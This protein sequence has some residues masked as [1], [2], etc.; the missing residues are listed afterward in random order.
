MP[1]LL[2]VN[3]YHYRRG[4]ADVVYFEHDLAFREAGWETAM[5]AMHHPSNVPSPWSDYF[6][7]ELQY[8]HSYGLVNKVGMAAKV[9]F[10]V[11]ARRK[12]ARLLDAFKPNIAHSHNL[13]H[14]I[15]PSILPLLKQRGI[16]SVMT[17]HDLKLACPSHTMLAAD[18]ICERCKGGNFLNVVRH[19][20]IKGSLGVSGLVA[21][22]SWV[23]KVLGLYRNNLDRIVV[24][25]RFYADKFVAWGWPAHQFAYIPNF[26]KHS[27]F[28]PDYT[29][30]DYLVYLGRMSYEKGVGALLQAARLTGA[31]LVLMGDGELAGEVMATARDAPNITYLGRKS[32][33]ELADVVRAARATIL[34]SEWYENAP[35]SVLEGFALGKPALGA[36]I[37]GIPEMVRPGSTGWLFQSGNVDS[38]AQVIETVMATPDA[39][40]AELGRSAR[41]VV[42]NEYSRECYMREMKRLYSDLGVRA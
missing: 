27:E 7:D 29:P 17:A 30:G 24:P 5:F 6:V 15:S 11:E 9:I 20:C 2:N 39:A 3:S 26:V 25:S 38:L 13:Y 22:E 12:L 36:D 14:H 41:G 32:G 35:M 18:G 8:G 33:T 34:P 23:H 31:K 10:S 37:G 4:G 42:E 21:L 19:K 16:P 1:R 40:V 28:R